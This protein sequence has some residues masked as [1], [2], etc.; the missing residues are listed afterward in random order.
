MAAIPLATETAVSRSPQ[1]QNTRLVNFFTE[2]QTPGAKGQAPLFSAPGITNMVTC[3]EGPVRGLWNFNGFAYAVSGAGLYLVREDGSTNH[4]GDGIGGT[5]PVEMSD[6]GVQLGMVNGVNGW[7]YTLQS[8]NFQQISDPAFE[9]ARTIDFMDGYF[10][11]DAF[12]TNEWFLSQLYDGLTYDALDFATAEAQPGFV[13]GTAQNLQLLF[14]FC[15]A[16]I[17]LWYDAGTE[18]FPFQRYAGGII[19]YGC[20][21]PYTITKQDGALFFL[22]ADRVFYR[23]Q[24]NVP[25]R[26]STHPIETM[27]ALESNLEACTTLTFTWEGHKMIALTLPTV[28]ATVVFDISTGKWHERESFTSKNISRGRWRASCATECYDKVLIGD[29]FSGQVGFIDPTVYTEFGE[30]M[31]GLIQSANV[32][33]DRKRVFVGRFELDLQFGVGL[34]SGQ[35]SDPQV[36]LERSIDGGMTWGKLQP[37]RSM[38]RQGQYLRR[39]R[40]LRQGQGREMMWRLTFSDPTPRTVIGAYADVTPGM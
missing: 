18:D 7:I 25:I 22:G 11:F 3:P 10:I 39:A 16:H 14:I 6:N 40:W 24:A 29:A 2:R 23:L 17:E 13:V 1:L 5:G 35:G 30:P 32:H 4:L 34:T 19:N 20:V 27:I 36:M 38:G 9:S 21:S 37:W 26:V 8:G 12:G 28:G 31:L 15:S 33:H